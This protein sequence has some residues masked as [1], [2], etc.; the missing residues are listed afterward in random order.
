V[1]HLLI[2]RV[3]SWCRSRHEKKQGPV[4]HKL[5]PA[6]RS[7]FPGPQKVPGINLDAS[8]PFLGL[9][10][11]MAAWVK[12]PCCHPATGCNIVAQLRRISPWASHI[13]VP[14]VQHRGAAASNQLT[15]TSGT[16][17]EGTGWIHARDP[18]RISRQWCAPTPSRIRS[19]GPYRIC[20][21]RGTICTRL[22]RGCAL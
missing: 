17:C 11:A 16:A 18:D 19:A 12:K 5:G 14:V 9:G 1:F 13:R 20:A 7:F 6:R 3:A 21:N 2:S 22:P 4:R 15:D 10:T 8:L